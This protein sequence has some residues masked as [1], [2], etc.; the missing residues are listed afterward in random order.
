MI[1][2]EDDFAHP[3]NPQVRCAGCGEPID[4]DLEAYTCGRGKMILGPEYVGLMV[5]MHDRCAKKYV[6][7]FDGLTE[8]QWADMMAGFEDG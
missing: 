2:P 7:P 6:A 8:G 4:R 3:D 1:I 5:S